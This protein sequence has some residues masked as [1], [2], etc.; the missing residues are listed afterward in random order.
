MIIILFSITAILAFLFET[1]KNEQFG[2]QA[3]SFWWAIVTF[4]TTGYGDKVPVTAGG[5]IVAVF[6]IFIGVIAMSSLSGTLAS[7]F[8]D[9]NTKAR[10]G[11]MEFRNIKNHIIICGWK[12]HMKEI[13]SDILKVTESREAEDL[14]L[15]SNVEPEKIEE[16]RETQALK[17]IRFVRGDYFSE[18]ALNKA[19]LKMANKIIV[20]ADTLESKAVSEVDSKTV[21][22]V[23]TAR[24]IS[25]DVYVC[26]EILD[27]KYETYLKNAACDEIIF[28][29]EMSRRIL[30][31]T[32]ATNGLSHIVFDFLDYETNGTR[33]TTCDIPAEFVGRSY[34][35]Y[36]CSYEKRDDKTLIG[37]LEN[38]GTPNQMKIEALRE[39]QKT[40]DTAAMVAN[41]QK[42]KELAVNNP[43]LLPPPG[44][45]I[46][47][48]AKAI[49]VERL[50]VLA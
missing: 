19:N 21:M 1:G 2:S 5:R 29:E 48:H 12:D 31:G 37:I 33:L 39:A 35:D 28:L 43:V 3:D 14:I 40:S 38:T 4:T 10:R 17:G 22:T 46:Q 16:L 26:A 50:E 49:I 8:I 24:T 6:N 20:M 34:S 7:V 32:T 11:M 47:K 23:L 15:I 30:A 27:R 36:R 41:L 13:L 9:R 25:K 42:V 45:V 44:Y 18:T